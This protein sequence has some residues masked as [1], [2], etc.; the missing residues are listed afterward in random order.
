MFKLRAKSSLFKKP[1][2]FKHIGAYFVQSSLVTTCLVYTYRHVLHANRWLVKAWLV[3][4]CL[5]VLRALRAKR[6]LCKAWCASMC[7]QWHAHTHTHTHT[8]SRENA[9][10]FVTV[11]SSHRRHEAG[12][13]TPQQI[14]Q[15]DLA[16]PSLGRGKRGVGHLGE[17]LTVTFLKDAVYD[18]VLKQIKQVKT[19]VKVK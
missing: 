8:H 3:Y 1:C 6:S 10:T 11:S 17:L 2:S 18:I 7:Q 12:Q 5:H 14:Q 9:H 16:N 15:A 19:P 4:T 13:H